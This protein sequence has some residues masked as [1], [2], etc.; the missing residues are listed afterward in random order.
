MS[1]GGPRPWHA[2]AAL[3]TARVTGLAYVGFLLG[4]VYVGWWAE[5]TGNPSAMLAVAA[6]AATLTVL[7]GALVR[8]T[9]P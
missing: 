4:P 8:P 2:Y 6:L 7:A 5:W 1:P 9:R 3:A